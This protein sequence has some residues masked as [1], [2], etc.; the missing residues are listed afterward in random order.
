[1]FS[2]R[3]SL[4]ITIT[5]FINLKEYLLTNDCKGPIEGLLYFEQIRSEIQRNFQSTLLSLIP[6]RFVVS[7]KFLLASFEFKIACR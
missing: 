5:M 6:V 3:F 4:L 1:L 7:V 2:R